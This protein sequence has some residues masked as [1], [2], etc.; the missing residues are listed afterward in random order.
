MFH[1]S[2]SGTDCPVCGT[3]KA[4]GAAWAKQTRRE[5]GRLK[6]FAAETEAVHKAA[7]EARKQAVALVAPPPEAL[8]VQLFNIGVDGL[9]AARAE[10]KQWHEGL[11][12][13]TW[14][15]RQSPREGHEAF[16]DAIG[17]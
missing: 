11:H 17:G 14:R 8:L 5:I 13:P 16:T 7:D 6:A 2:H 15:L 9:D 3:K 10:S 4:I 12:S 1:E